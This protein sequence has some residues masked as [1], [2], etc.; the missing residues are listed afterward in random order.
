MYEQPTQ[1]TSETLEVILDGQ[2]VR[3]PAERRSISAVRAYLETLALECE[4]VLCS[5]KVDTRPV[6][7]SQLPGEIISHTRIEGQTV[8]LTDMPLR[9]LETAL[10]ETTQARMAVENAVTLVLINEGVTARELWWELARTLKEPLL[11]LSL[12]PETIYQPIA[13]T[14]S[15]LQMRK[16]QFQQLAAIIKDVDEACWAQNPETLSNA[17]ESRALPWLDK[18]R[19]SIQLLH[20]TVLVGARLRN[21]ENRDVDQRSLY[22]R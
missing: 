17:L 14:A 12:L 5:F 19:E 18:L 21:I 22:N 15:L 16:W 20:Q 9:M 11:T 6:K 10:R 7:S 13:G 1:S 8:A 3:L 4:R 2:P